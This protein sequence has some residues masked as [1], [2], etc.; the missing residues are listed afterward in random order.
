MHS[1]DPRGVRFGRRPPAVSK[2]DTLIGSQRGSEDYD[3]SF[4]E[5]CHRNRTLLRW[6][7]LDLERFSSGIAPPPLSVHAE[8]GVQGKR[9]RMMRVWST[10]SSLAS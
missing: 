4:G 6:L 10:G 8:T 9:S 2:S 7:I 5:G 3:T 1:N